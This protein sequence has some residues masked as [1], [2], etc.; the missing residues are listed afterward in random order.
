MTEFVSHTRRHVGEGAG[1][2][3]LTKGFVPCGRLLRAR[4][5]GLAGPTAWFRRQW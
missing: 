1:V 4:R 3:A 2:M 5:K